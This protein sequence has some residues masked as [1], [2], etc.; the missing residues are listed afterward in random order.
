MEKTFAF[1]LLLL[2]GWEPVFSTTS[3]AEPGLGRPVFVPVPPLTLRVSLGNLFNLYVPQFPHPPNGG[4]N[5]T[6]LI[7]RFNSEYT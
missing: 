3:R 2:R 1:P 5:S 6:Y 4:D 7:G